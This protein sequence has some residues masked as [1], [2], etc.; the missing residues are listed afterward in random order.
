[1]AIQE[2]F[3]FAVPGSALDLAAWAAQGCFDLVLDVAGMD[4]SGRDRRHSPHRLPQAADCTADHAGRGHRHDRIRGPGSLGR[5]GADH[6]IARRGPSG[7]G[8]CLA[9]AALRTCS[10][11]ASAHPVTNCRTTVIAAR[12]CSRKCLGPRTSHPCIP[13]AHRSG[14]ADRCSV[15]IDP[16]RGSSTPGYSIRRCRC[17][18][19]RCPG[20]CAGGCACRGSRRRCRWGRLSARWTPPGPR[21]A[22]AHLSMPDGRTPKRPRSPRCRRPGEPYPILGGEWSGAVLTL[23]P[24]TAPSGKSGAR[25]DR[26][27][28]ARMA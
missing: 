11:R 9:H 28:A 4:L 19:R 21:S 13:Q 10:T 23:R 14:R 22:E 20:R 25:A 1:M 18:T 3:H 26:S 12:A 17:P 15:R 7:G 27:A 2:A 24:R 8:V 6:P 5:A 16:C